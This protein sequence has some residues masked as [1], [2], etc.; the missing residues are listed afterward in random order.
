MSVPV[1]SVVEPVIASRPPD[2]CWYIYVFMPWDVWPGCSQDLDSILQ[3]D[4]ARHV[5]ARAPGVTH[6]GRTA[7]GWAL[8]SVLE[9]KVA[10]VGED[11]GW[12]GWS[13]YIEVNVVVQQG[14]RQPVR[15]GTGSLVMWLT[16]IYYC[17][18]TFLGGAF[19]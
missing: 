1:R 16:C 17:F 15:R 13:L 4:C 18:K 19:Y 10:L 6:S 14:P 7:G 2:C 8:V 12:V 3:Q 11:Q 9:E 5:E